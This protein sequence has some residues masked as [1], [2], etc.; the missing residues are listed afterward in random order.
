[1]RTITLT[2]GKVTLIDDTDYDWLSQWKWHAL[3]HHSGYFYA[4]R[5]T[6]RI[7]GKQKSIRMHRQILRLEPGDKREGDHKNHNTLDNRRSNLRICTNRQNSMNRKSI[8]NTTSK[9]KGVCWDKRDKKWKAA[10]KVN[11]KVKNLG[12]F[13]DEE[14]AALTYNKVATEHFG[15]F[16]H[17]NLNRK[18]KN[19]RI[20]CS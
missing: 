10:I 17:L 9:Y 7:N 6:P 19:A 15:E 3:K 11:G 8:P 14:E 13:A 1:M 16:A 12:Y 5:M 4:V 20:F 18:N 2:Q